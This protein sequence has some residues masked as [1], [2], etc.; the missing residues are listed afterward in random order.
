MLLHASEETE[1]SFLRAMFSAFSSS[2]DP[3]DYH[4]IWHQREVL[5]AMGVIN[6][7][8]LHILDMGFVSQLLC[9]GKVHWAIYVA[10]HLPHREDYP[11]LHVNL[12]RE[13]L[14]QYCETWSS[15]ESQYRFIEDLGIPK[16]WMHEALVCNMFFYGFLIFYNY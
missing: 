16:E 9:L 4:M 5:E 13:I 12:I 14:F 3:L 7:N 1:F 11:Y 2:P 8:D 6:S 15:D 10:L